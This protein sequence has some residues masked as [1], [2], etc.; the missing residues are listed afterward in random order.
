VVG[1]VAAVEEENVKERE[2]R[3]GGGGR[4]ST[5]TWWCWPRKHLDFVMVAAEAK[6]RKERGCCEGGRAGTANGTARKEEE[7]EKAMAKGKSGTEGT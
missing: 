4:R 3:G 1:G 7:E 6:A 5:S 2:R